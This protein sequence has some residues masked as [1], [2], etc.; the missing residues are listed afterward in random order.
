MDDITD[1][2]CGNIKGVTGCRVSAT[3]PITVT[4][5]YRGLLVGTKL[6]LSCL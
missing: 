1:A 6:I 4:S 3:N 5:S 2:G